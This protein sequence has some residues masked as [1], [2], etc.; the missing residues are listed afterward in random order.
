MN[1][2]LD[3]L[4]EYKKSDVRWIDLIFRHSPIFFGKLFPPEGQ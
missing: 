2:K 4:F 3:L 1:K